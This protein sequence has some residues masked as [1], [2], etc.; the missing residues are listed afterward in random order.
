MPRRSGAPGASGSV[1]RASTG[2]GKGFPET[3]GRVS[4]R[5]FAGENGVADER[6]GGASA[7]RRKRRGRDED[8][9]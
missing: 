8:N 1:H 3:G 7:G 2:S 4:D 6:L 9:H 5:Y